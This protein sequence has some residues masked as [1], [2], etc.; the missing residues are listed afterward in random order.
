MTLAISVRALAVTMANFQRCMVDL[1]RSRMDSKFIGL[2]INC[3]IGMDRS[4]MAVKMLAV[5][6]RTLAIAVRT[7]SMAVNMLAVTRMTLANDDG[8][9]SR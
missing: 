7:L 2:V 5:A 1:K 6:V 9:L 8:T 4:A 3:L